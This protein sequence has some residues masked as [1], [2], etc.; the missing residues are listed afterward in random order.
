VLD[1]IFFGS[2]FPFGSPAAAV[3]A[4]YS[5]NSYALGT[6]LP[7]I[8]RSALRL[9]VERN[10]ITTLGMKAPLLI[11]ISSNVGHN[12]TGISP[13]P[14]PSDRVDFGASQSPYRR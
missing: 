8:P 14:T 9:I 12:S 3:E 6:N 7:S 10:P 1:K 11:G 13:A 4:I 5:L 2:G